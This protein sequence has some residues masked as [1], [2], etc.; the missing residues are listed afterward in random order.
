[1]TKDA[2]SAAQRRTNITT[3][4]A[5]TD[6]SPASHKALR[7]AAA[8]ATRSGATLHIVHVS[9]IDYAIPGPALLAQDPFTSDT[10]NG[11][12]LKQ[13]VEAQIGSCLSP[14][15]HGRTGRAFDQICRSARELKAD[16]V[17]M[18]THGRTGLKR[19]VLG[20]NAERVV[21]HSSAP[22]LIVR[23]SEREF[24]S[25]GQQ[26]Q[27]NTI[28]IPTDFS[29]SAREALNYALHFARRFGSRLVLF[30]SFNVPQFVAT[31]QYGPHRFGCEPEEL[32]AAAEGQMRELVDRVDFGG[33]QFETLIQPGRAA[34]AICAYAERQKID[35]IITS[36]HGRTGLMHVLIGS[37]AEHIVRYAR[38]PVLVVPH[39]HAAAD[40]G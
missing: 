36:T 22:V 1:M 17:V 19:F 31:D 2:A 20:S 13:Q 14:I 18:A 23:E 12:A 26:L 21:Q 27:V 7:Y 8:L 11:R 4:L 37:V 5:P 9:E 6:F 16:L 34:E 10:E 28:L 33:V 3:V 39:R 24:L 15:F 25:D 29:D 32:Q 40:S 38:C 30:H 35:L